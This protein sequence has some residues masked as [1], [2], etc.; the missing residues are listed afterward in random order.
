MDVA[1]EVGC[2]DLGLR[3]EVCGLR[4]RWKVGNHGYT[5]MV[6]SLPEIPWPGGALELFLY[7]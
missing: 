6:N 4:F 1:K 2:V 5:Q 7:G 3:G